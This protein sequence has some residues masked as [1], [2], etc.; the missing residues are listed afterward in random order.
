L[1][2]TATGS[3][4]QQIDYDTFG[5]VLLDTNPG[6]QP[7]GFAGGLYDPD[8]RLTRYGLR[9]YDAETGGWATKDPRGFS[10]GPN[11]YV[12]AANDPV[13]L[14]D[15]L[16]DNPRNPYVERTI[17]AMRTPYPPAVTPEPPPSSPRVP[18]PAPAVEPTISLGPE[19][20]G[21][22][23]REPL[24]LPEPYPPPGG[25]TRLPSGWGR[26]CRATPY[27]A[28]GIEIGYW[29]YL[30]YKQ[31]WGQLTQSVVR[32]TPVGDTGWGAFDVVQQ[33]S[34]GD[35]QGAGWTYV[36]NS[37]PIIGLG[38]W[39]GERLTSDA[40]TLQPWK[41]EWWPF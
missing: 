2:D 17:A 3:V 9:D 33:A 18:S 16:G 14:M 30:A 22:V 41:A 10:G 35:L 1:I 11:L 31:E 40:Y 39:A 19:P 24:S 38:A 27:V 12:Y 4:A 8:T 32:S 6:F 34:A 26:I 5:T 28:A 29:G 36:K 23:A 25:G 20:L 7:F 15:P 13:N 21:R 37:V